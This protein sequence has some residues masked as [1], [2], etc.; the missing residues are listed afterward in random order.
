MKG[1]VKTAELTLCADPGASS[2]AAGELE[3]E[4]GQGA[5]TTSKMSTARSHGASG[6]KRSTLGDTE[7]SHWALL[8]FD[9][10]PTERHN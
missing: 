5:H 6:Q 1:Q 2:L 7:D 9:V 10:K 8:V 4:A 3:L